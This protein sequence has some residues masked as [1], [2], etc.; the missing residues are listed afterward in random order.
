M[1]G[2]PVGGVG[3]GMGSGGV[4]GIGIGGSSECKKDLVIY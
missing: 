3:L 2:G 1:G 4:G